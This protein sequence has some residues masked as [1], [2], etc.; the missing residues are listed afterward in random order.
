MQ[1]TRFAAL[2]FFPLLLAILAV[3]TPNPVPNET[4]PVPTVTVTITATATA[5][6]V[7]QCNTGQ[8][9][10]CDSSEN[11]NS[12]AAQGL[13]GLLGIVIEGVTGLLGLDCS[14]ITIGLAG[15]GG[16]S[17]QTLC[18]ENNTFSTRSSA[19]L[20]TRRL[21]ECFRYRRYYRLWLRSDHYHAL[22]G[23]C[24]SEPN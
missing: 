1:L 18:C 19:F 20:F 4:T 13:L 8:L 21:T 15:G 16:C 23:R 12:P 24:V 3:A 22:S 9:L 11:A 17:A 6:P 5:T 10:C 14:G 7:S 2:V